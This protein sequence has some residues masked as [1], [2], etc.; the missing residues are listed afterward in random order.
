M[1]KRYVVLVCATLVLI[2]SLFACGE[3]SRATTPPLAPTLIPTSHV[4]LPLVEHL[5]F[6]GDVSGVLVAGD[7]PRPLTHDNPIPT[8]VANS[9]GTYTAPAPMWTQCSDFDSGVG[10]DYV[11]VIAGNVGHARYAL[12]IEINEDNPAYTKPG[13]PLSPGTTN[14][15][16][17]V[18][19][20][21]SAVTGKRWQ[22]VYGPNGQDTVI[23]L[24]PD[25]TSGTIDAWLATT[26]Q[27]Q[28]DATATLHMQG[29]WRCG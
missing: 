7:A 10:Q 14:S 19:V 26:D 27:S 28:K 25:R 24:H 18:E 16:G 15:G 12:T 21:Q 1:S 20:Y 29:S 13:T 3:T 17:S 4:T 23:V 11:A 22:Q 9:D 8:Y 5:A 6:S 2:G